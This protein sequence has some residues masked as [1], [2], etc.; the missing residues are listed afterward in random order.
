MNDLFVLAKE[1]AHSKTIIKKEIKVDKNEIAISQPEIAKP[2]IKII[3]SSSNTGK[4]PVNPHHT[5][6]ISQRGSK[7]V[8]PLIK[9]RSGLHS[10]KSSSNTSKK[11]Y[12][13]GKTPEA[14]ARKRRIN[15]RNMN[16]GTNTDPE[17][18]RKYNITKEDILDISKINI[19][20][21]KYFNLN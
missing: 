20:V 3:P 5:C 17:T 10:K 8:S 9:S 16:N 12:D 14:I 18:L 1:K 7:W 21:V 11:I 19:N 13:D 6:M 2:K 4:T 15:I